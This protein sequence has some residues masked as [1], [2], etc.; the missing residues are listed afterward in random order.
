MADH[1]TPEPL[2]GKLETY[3]SNVYGKEESYNST[4]ADIGNEI[5]QCATSFQEAAS[6]ISGA[7]QDAQGKTLTQCLTL[8]T[9]ACTRMKDSIVSEVAS[10]GGKCC[11][12]DGILDEIKAKQDYVSSLTKSLWIEEAW[13][14]LG[15]FFA[16]HW[17]NSN[18][19]LAKAANEEIKQLIKLAESQLDAI[20]GASGSIELGINSSNMVSGGSLGAYSS[21]ND[22]YSFNRQQWIDAN[23]IAHLNVLQQAGCV[24]AG[25][26]ESVVKVG[27]GIVDVAL[28][29]AAGVT[30][31]ITGNDD[32]WFRQAAE[33][34][35]AG[36]VGDG[37]ST[38]L[39]LGTVSNEQYHESAG[40]SVGNFAGSVV[41]HGALWASGLGILSAAAVGGNS[42]EKHLQ[43]GETVGGSF[44]SGLWDGTKAYAIGHVFSA[45]GGKVMPHLSNWA[46]TSSNILARGYRAAATSF[47]SGWGS[48][49]LGTK[50]VSVVASPVRG[51][52]KGLGK[53]I[54]G[55]S[56]LL[57]RTVGATRVGSALISADRAVSQGFENVLDK[58]ID[59][60]K[61]VV[62]RGREAVGRTAG[63]EG[64]GAI[65]VTNQG[66]AA[67]E[68]LKARVEANEAAMNSGK[69]NMSQTSGDMRPA[70]SDLG[71]P[72][73]ED[74]IFNELSDEKFLIEQYKAAK[75]IL[76]NPA[77]SPADQAWARGVIKD[78][79]TTV[80]TG[81]VT[82][83]NTLSDPAA[84][85]TT[86]STA[87]AGRTLP[88]SGDTISAS[89]LDD[90]F[91]IMDNPSASAADRAWA[92]NVIDMADNYTRPT[93]EMGPADSM[94]N[95]HAPARITGATTDALESGRTTASATTGN[96]QPLNYED[97]VPTQIE[98][99]EGTLGYEPA[100]FMDDVPTTARA[101]STQPLNY[102][103][104]VPTQIE[105]AEGTLGYEPAQFMDDVPKTARVAST[106]P[107]NYEDYVP[108]Q[109]ET[110]EGTL[111]YEPAQFM[112]D[113]ATTA[114]V[115]IPGTEAKMSYNEAQ[116]NIRQLTQDGFSPSTYDPTDPFEVEQYKL[117][118]DSAATIAD[119]YPGGKTATLRQN[120]NWYSNAENAA[121]YYAD[122]FLAGNDGAWEP[123][124]D[125]VYRVARI[126]G[127]STNGSTSVTQPPISVQPTIPQATPTVTVG[128]TTPPVTPTVTTG[129]TTPPVT[130]TVTVGPTTPPVTP[131]VT[132]TVTPT[133]TVT[134]TAGSDGYFNPGVL[135]GAYDEYIKNTRGQQGQ[136]S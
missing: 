99:A 88:A 100:Q 54:T 59:T 83:E 58:G 111:G 92:K 6:T 9:D 71:A 10:I 21:F 5:N 80:A 85:T 29:A 70:A 114:R 109:I 66:D 120:S 43:N 136:E 68:K 49:S 132:A 73:A 130:P 104:Y 131:A 3:K 126:D 22:N 108:T 30:S 50:I 56:D 14:D 26:V 78:A 133:P 81:K 89:E 19:G 17:N 134:T 113:A 125:N 79:N 121:N 107:L 48:N 72:T 91:S 102:E 122:E 97:Y 127:S 39:T 101:A 7:V 25:A 23:P 35:L 96:T 51:V 38:A 28:T 95:E 118:H 33:Y 1:Y 62:Q 116:A 45:V 65:D 103:D 98:T 117:W 74:S 47:G 2:S 64:D 87:S 67:A 55:G 82:L 86:T 129:P 75:G 124:A 123:F 27:E 16:G 4:A 93:T 44:V 119:T 41:A 20:A 63:A 42:M 8:V 115:G 24:V 135:V 13:D 60:A 112:D 57:T 32:N 46:N 110:A 40:R 69:G 84:T 18:H 61:N 11:E 77:S 36:K 106:Q 128:P 34:D 105:T 90:A 31:L 37:L 15:H 53:A 76:D 12:V 52:V 94:L